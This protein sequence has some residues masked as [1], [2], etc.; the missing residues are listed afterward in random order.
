[1]HEIHYT[2]NMD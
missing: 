1:M 2:R